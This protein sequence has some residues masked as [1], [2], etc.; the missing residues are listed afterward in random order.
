M[1]FDYNYKKSD[2]SD[3]GEYLKLKTLAG[4]NVQAELEENGDPFRLDDEF[5][6]WY[7]DREC[8]KAFDPSAAVNSNMTV[9]A[10]WKSAESG[11]TDSGKEVPGKKGCG[12]EICGMTALIACALALTLALKKKRY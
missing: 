1:T 3:R 2:G 10:K 8:T 5:L 12:S 4:G 6:G 7:V 9:Y 11:G